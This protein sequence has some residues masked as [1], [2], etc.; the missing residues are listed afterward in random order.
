MDYLPDEILFFHI[1]SQLGIQS[2]VRCRLVCKRFRFWIDRIFL[3]ELAFDNMRKKKQIYWFDTGAPIAAEHVLYRFDL[4]RMF[5]IP[6][7]LDRLRRLCL[8]CHVKTDEQ[9]D[10]GSINYLKIC[11]LNEFVRLEY[12]SI[13]SVH[14]AYEEI[15]S[16]PNL[17]ALDIFEITIHDPFNPFNGLAACTLPVNN[18]VLQAPRLSVLNCEIGLDH[19]SV[20]SAESVRELSI[21]DKQADLSA[22]RCCEVF[23]CDWPHSLNDQILQQLPNLKRLHLDEDES[24]LFD[25][26]ETG[27]IM[28]ALLYQKKRLKR[29][30]LAVYF[31]DHLLEDEKR[32]DD[33]QFDL[34]YSD[35]FA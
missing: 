10:T 24:E 21:G 17:K 14:V 33:Y 7:N 6:F 15:L 18:L 30:D 3:K 4:K 11:M 20:L 1:F 19:L 29:R 2:L 5:E 9:R 22:Y 28:D 27:R 16:L 26:K 13:Q 25:Y 12:L 8:N 23:K 35:V 32:F 31:L 34:I